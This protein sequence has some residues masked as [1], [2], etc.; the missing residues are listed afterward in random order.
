MP[1]SLGNKAGTENQTFQKEDRTV[2]YEIG[3]VVRRTVEPIGRLKRISVAVLVDGTYQQVQA[4]G[5][6]DPGPTYIPRST[7]EMAKLE[8]LVKRAV[9]FDA[10]RG[11]QV[12]IANIAFDH[13]ALGGDPAAVSE[14]GWISRIKSLG[15]VLKYALVAF[16]ILLAFMFVVRPLVQWLTSGNMVSGELLKQLPKTVSEIERGIRR[17]PRRTQPGLPRSDHPVAQYGQ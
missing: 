7:E 13:A 11:D 9:N 5:Q 17:C 10:Q 3:K 12:E 1:L 4:E 6:E 16:F 14:S 8:N 2:N 15:A